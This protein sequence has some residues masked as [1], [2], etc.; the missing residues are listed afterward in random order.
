MAKGNL[1]PPPSGA[2]IFLHVEQEAEAG[3][4]HLFSATAASQR[5]AGDVDPAL[6]I[7]GQVDWDPPSA[8]T[9][10]SWK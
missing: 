7:H 6:S 9:D 10:A 5:R 2:D 8:I 3:L 1:T 4:V